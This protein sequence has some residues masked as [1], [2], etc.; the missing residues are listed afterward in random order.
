[1]S[2]AQYLHKPIPGIT[3]DDEA[4]SLCYYKRGTRTGYAF[5][6]YGDEQAPVS[7]HKFPEG[8]V[9][10]WPLREAYQR[11]W[12]LYSDSVE[13]AYVTARMARD[14]S[15]RVI[16]TIPRDKI[17]LDP[18]GHEFKA[19]TVYIAPYC[20][21]EIPE[22]TILYNG[23]KS[24]RTP[25]N[26]YR[27]SRIR[28]VDSTESRVPFF[29]GVE[30]YK[31]LSH[32]CDC[33]PNIYHMGRFGVWDKNVLLHNVWEDAMEYANAMKWERTNALH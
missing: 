3:E 21:E 19:Q 7:W 32:T 14:L 1:M 2:G 17:C 5:N 15:G 11:L 27:V 13:D 31:P 6:T 20:A 26:Y 22:D 4:F 18:E 29:G 12:D 25:K 30:G 10:A 23:M 33:H 8:Y 9:S 16:N 24:F 28:G